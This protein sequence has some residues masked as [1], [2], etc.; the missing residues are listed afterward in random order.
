MGEETILYEIKTNITPNAIKENTNGKIGTLNSVVEKVTLVDGEEISRETVKDTNV[1]YKDL[2]EGQKLIGNELHLE[3]GYE[4]DHENEDGSDKRDPK[5][6]SFVKASANVNGKNIENFTD[7]D[8]DIIDE[9][10]FTPKF[11]KNKIQLTDKNGNLALMEDQ[12]TKKRY[13]KY[14]KMLAQHNTSN[15]EAIS[16]G[17]VQKFIE[18]SNGVFV[19]EKINGIL[20]A[21][22]VAGP[23]AGKYI[24]RG[25]AH[26][27]ARYTIGEV[28][29]SPVDENYKTAVNTNLGH[30]YA[31]IAND[32]EAF[33]VTYTNP[34]NGAVFVRAKNDAELSAV[35]GILT[36]KDLGE[37][38]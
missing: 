37:A 8:I 34:T 7:A 13:E 5:L 19:G 3:A 10:D 1:T 32:P 25:K 23:H 24:A 22:I 11:G 28:L 27:A 30:A 12:V 14:V 33:V 15:M 29:D 9:T 38:L 18:A 17:S 26:E 2:P 4:A 35:V 31:Q 6:A 16:D 36:A 21:K 20:Y